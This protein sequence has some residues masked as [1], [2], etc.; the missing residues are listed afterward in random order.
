MPRS[1]ETERIARAI[2]ART[3]R[4]TP[5]AASA[6]VKPACAPRRSS[7]PV[8][9]PR[10]EDE[11]ATGQAL[12]PQ[13]AEDDLRVG[14]GRLGPAAPV[15]C[16]AGLGPRG[17]RADTQ[18]AALVDPPDAAAARA[19]RDHVEARRPERQPVDRRLLGD[20]RMQI[21]DDG[22]IGRRAAHVERDDVP[23]PAR[24]R[25]PR[26]AEHAGGRTREHRVDGRADRPRDAAHAAAGPH[27]ADARAGHV[28]DATQ[29]PLEDGLYVRVQRRRRRALV[30]TELGK[31]VARHRDRDIRAEHL[32][33]ELGH[34][35]L[36]R[37]VRVG[38]EQTDGDAV[39]AAD[40]LERPPDGVLVELAPHL[41]VGADPFGDADAVRRVRERCGA[42]RAEVVQR[43]TALT[44]ELQQVTEPLRRHE[45]ELG[46]RSA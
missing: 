28:L 17:T 33:D 8:A 31:H 22:D 40:L 19:D 29:V 27:H 35:L 25:R 26:R 13:V 6:R 7:A 11:V 15:A 37:R 1:T 9:A 45:R 42:S 36:V 41:S 18:R 34:A 16:R 20:L 44:R 30:L 5:S 38:V 23:D 46:P 14:D 21:L 24:A 32:A 4:N 39:D 3:T 12:G 2:V 10:V 43:R